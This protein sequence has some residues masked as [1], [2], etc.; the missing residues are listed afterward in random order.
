[1]DPDGTL[2]YENRPVLESVVAYGQETHIPDHDICRLSYY[3]K[4]CVVGCGIELPTSVLSSL[5]LPAQI[6]LPLFPV[7]Q[8]QRQQGD[9]TLPE[10]DTSP[11][12]G[13]LVSSCLLDYERAHLLPESWQT[14]IRRL[15]F[16]VFSYDKMMNSAI[17]LDDQHVLLPLGTLNTFF[18]I[19]TASTYFT[20]H[21]YFTD[22]TSGKQVQVH[23]VML[24]TTGWIQEYFVRPFIRDYQDSV[25]LMMTTTQLMNSSPLDRSSSTQSSSASAQPVSSRPV[26]PPMMPSIGSSA[27]SATGSVENFFAFPHNVASSGGLATSQQGPVAAISGGLPS[28]SSLFN[29]DSRPPPVAAAAAAAAAASNSRQRDDTTSVSISIPQVRSSIE[30]FVS[31]LSQY[32]GSV[33]PQPQQHQQHHHRHHQEAQDRHLQDL[34]HQVDAG[35]VP[36][37]DQND[38]MIILPPEAVHIQPL[39]EQRDAF[40]PDVPMAAAVIIP[41]DDEIDDVE[42]ESDDEDDDHDDDDVDDEDFEL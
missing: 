39:N 17:I 8:H 22:I 26:I 40:V 29:L 20:V 38:R 9:E 34:H 4:C 2:R 21:N 11:P 31:L 1:M 23:K 24:C 28:L 42:A 33:P 5:L 15:A 36:G 18:E 12:S 3:L 37:R 25:L 30:Q 35:V 32:I 27:I 14:V 19:K 6:L 41:D 7:P 10:T 13:G 16:N